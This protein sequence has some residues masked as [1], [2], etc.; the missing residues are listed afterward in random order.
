MTWKGGIFKVNKLLNMLY[1]HVKH[2][3]YIVEPRRTGMGRIIDL[4]VHFLGNKL[5]P[6]MILTE[7]GKLI[8][9]PKFKLKGKERVIV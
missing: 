9:L 2:T 1:T 6:P 8:L 5:S 3:A 4:C 7:Y